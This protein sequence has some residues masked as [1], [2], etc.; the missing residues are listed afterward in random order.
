[1]FFNFED[2]KDAKN[3]LHFIVVVRDRGGATFLQKRL[4]PKQMLS[5][6]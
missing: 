5:T 6:F 2:S 3:N 1:M 4:P